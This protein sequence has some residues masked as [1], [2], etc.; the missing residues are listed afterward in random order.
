VAREP[1][2][3]GAPTQPIMAQAEGTGHPTRQGF[4]IVFGTGQ[5]IEP[6]DT[7]PTRPGKTF[8][9]QSFYGIWDKDDKKPVS[10]QTQV[11][12][13]ELLDQALTDVG[14]VRLVPLASPDWSK[15]KG[16]KMDFPNSITTGERAVFRPIL[17][18][19]R[20]I[21][22]TLIPVAE[23]CAGGGTSILM[24]I[25]PATGSR[26]DGPVIDV[27]ADGILNDKDQVTP[28][29]YASGIKS[30]VGISPTPVVVRGGPNLQ[31]TDN[32]SKIFGT[33]Q[34]AIVGA[35]GVLGFTFMGGPLGVQGLWIGLRSSA[36]R[37]SWREILTN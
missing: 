19:S 17:T 24:I 32:A 35:E 31:P 26:V 37:V 2:G 14:N 23:P 11:L 10:G 27:K 34:R 29:V 28:G 12:K 20:L 18:S 1:G 7:A 22:T 9:P 36:G 8:Q 30:E 13:T 15:H 6:T 33:T 16:W 5:Y 25:D 3:A 21:F 4:V